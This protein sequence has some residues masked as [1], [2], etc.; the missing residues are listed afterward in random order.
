MASTS[1]SRL[2]L[3]RA[4]V[5]LVTVVALGTPLLLGFFGYLA[6]GDGFEIN[7]GDPLRETRIWMIKENRRLRGLAMLRQTTVAQDGLQCA[8]ANYSALL[9]SPALATESNSTSCLCYTMDAAGQLRQSTTPC[10]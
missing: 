2:W 7:S 10:N 5:A 9:W 3:E 8:R 1:K 4:G 6:L